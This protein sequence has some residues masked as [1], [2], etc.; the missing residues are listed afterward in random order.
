M[1]ISSFHLVGEKALFQT[2]Y[3]IRDMCFLLAVGI[4]LNRDVEV[5]ILGTYFHMIYL[6]I[7]E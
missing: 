3:C 7:P 1:G 6:F 5:Y 4:E 2:R